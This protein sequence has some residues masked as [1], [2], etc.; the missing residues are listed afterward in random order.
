M[1]TANTTIQIKKSTL[2]KLKKLKTQ[3]NTPNYDEL[4][5]ILIEEAMNIP[6]SM[7]GIDKGKLKHFNN[8]DRFEFRKY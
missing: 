4:I 8:E 3:K 7:F 6:N 1:N 2:R 5:N